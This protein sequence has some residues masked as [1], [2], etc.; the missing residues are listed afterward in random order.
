MVTNLKKRKYLN[1]LNHISI[2]KKLSIFLVIPLATLL[3]FAASSVS[4]KQQQ[5]AGTEN[6]LHFSIIVNQLSKLIYQ[7][8]KER[9]LSAGAYGSKGKFYLEPL[10][11]QRQQTD[12]AIQDLLSLLSNNPSYATIDLREK[13]PHLTTEL[14]SLSPLRLQI[15]QHATH[16]FFG[17]YSHIINDILN[18]I[19]FMP[20]LNSTYE[21]NNLSSSYIELLWLEEFSGQERGA[22]NGV[23]SEQKFTAEQF[24]AISSY[25]SGQDAAIRNFNNTATQQHQQLLVNALS[26]PSNTD[27]EH[28]REVVLNRALRQD[29]LNGLQES[30]GYGGLI[31]NFKNH[32]I[33]SN[34]Q[35]ANLFKQNFQLAR[36]QIDAYRHLPN[37][38]DDEESALNTI[39]DTFKQYQNQLDLISELK[40][41]NLSIRYIDKLVKIDDGPAISAIN[42]LR[43]NIN[44]NDPELW[45]QQASTRLDLIHNVSKQVMQDLNQSAQFIKVETEDILNIYLLITFFILLFMGLF[46]VMLRSR[47][48]NEIKLIADSMRL[49]E[50]S[51][52]YNHLSIT[53]NDEISDL[54]RAFNSLIKERSEN[55]D[56][57]RLAARVFSDTHEGIIITDDKG[58]IIDVNPTFSELTGYDAEE[59]IGKNPSILSSGHHDEAFYSEMWQDLATNKFWQ[60]EVWNRKKDGTLYAE[61]ITITAIEGDSGELLR[62]IGIF[63]D[64]TQTKQQQEKLHL[65]AH[66]DV[67]TELPNRALFADRFSQAVAH[68]QRS[69]SQ[70]AV[71]F[72]DLDNFKPV[73]DNFGH[74]VGDQL[75]IEVAQRITSTIRAE[76][77]VSR[78]GGDEFALLLGDIESISQCDELLKRIHST[79]AQPYL[80]DGDVHN[81]SASIGSTIYPT[82]NADLDTLLRHADQAMYQ[83]KQA[84]KNHHV[85]FNVQHDKQILQQH[86]RLEEIEHALKNNEF[87][88]HYQAKVNMATGE[89]LG[90]EALIRWHHPKKGLIAPLDFLPI[91]EGTE[92]ENSIG[93]WVINQA[94]TQLDNWQKEGVFLEISVNIA[95]HHLQ[96]ETFFSQLDDALAKHPSVD[97]HDLQLEILESSAL[98]DLNT[99]S[100]II[101]NCQNVL[102]V[103]VALDDFGTGYSSL[104]HLRN[105]SA[106]TIKIDQSFVRD[107]LDDPSDYAIIDGIIGL[108]SAFRRK[109]IAEGVESTNHGLMLMIMGCEHAQGYCISKPL[110]AP[111]FSAWL[112]SYTPNKTW[113]EYGRQQLS[114]KENKV[115]LF[116]LVTENW[117][118]RFIHNVQSPAANDHNWPIFNAQ[119]DHCGQWLEREKQEKVFGLDGVKQLEKTHIEFHAVA[120]AIQNK[121]KNGEIE[122]ARDN[123]AGLKVAFDKM[124]N[125]LGMCE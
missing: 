100:A 50:R 38:N 98:G 63:S 5:L 113:L 29:A 102:G 118:N 68:S 90:A 75:L 53:G 36:E 34:I 111:E 114:I 104:T 123:L 2:S 85:F 43:H 95:S 84:G 6:T 121:Y 54:A 16:S 122:A 108:T 115:K 82:D 27:V 42:F 79:L 120:H 96:S 91:I 106:T 65:M 119:H 112:S 62:Y 41:Q 33:R 47:L 124:S 110:P 48:V 59:V 93:N 17:S 30:I 109:V 57:L 74:K 39:E 4:D 20:S 97:S 46:G 73:N 60:G 99:I 71:C 94:L 3:F 40:G 67:L 125:A 10:V 51:H 28:F 107:M 11:N 9:G 31:H 37:I 32:V 52:N 58:I 35:Y 8:Q 7:L 18:I 19:S 101:K 92:L 103:S 45:W 66:Y 12:S 26:H 116:R 64:I 88:L 86:L 21:L 56:Q 49:S 22:L 105:L 44:S 78:Q 81:V 89:V 69:T 117:M 13:L 23:F 1:F 72:L 83:A 80:I 61:L 15:D 77:T 24:S 55:E 70:L 25:I 87:V 76:D 14:S